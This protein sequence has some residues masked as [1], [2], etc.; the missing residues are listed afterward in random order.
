LATK[1]L[2]LNLKESAKVGWNSNPIKRN[3]ESPSNITPTSNFSTNYIK[4]RYD[5]IMEES[6]KQKVMIQTAQLK[7]MHTL[8]RQKLNILSN[9]NHPHA[10]IF[11]GYSTPLK[12]KKSSAKGGSGD[13]NELPQAQ[14]TNGP[15]IS[16]FGVKSGSNKILGAPK[17]NQD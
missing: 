15:V 2:N 7:R 12:H 4:E 14:V 17:E 5:K 1:E 3:E 9:S 11:S 10:N 8:T 13:S 6:T 16:N